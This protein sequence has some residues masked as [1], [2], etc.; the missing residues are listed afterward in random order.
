MVSLRGVVRVSASVPSLS[1]PHP[2]PAEL[3][4][5][6]VRSLSRIPALTPDCSGPGGGPQ[7]LTR[8]PACP[9]PETKPANP[10]TPNPA[11]PRLTQSSAAGQTITVNLALASVRC[12]GPRPQ[13]SAPV[14]AVTLNP[15]PDPSHQP[16]A[17]P[18]LRQIVPGPNTN[19]RLSR[20]WPPVHD[21]NPN[22]RHPRPLPPDTDT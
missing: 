12:T 3:T 2:Q 20:T 1:Q 11:R 4:L 13:P 21:P 17:A 10:Q 14:P 5:N 19:P 8:I 6:P 18:T 9:G 7:P 22:A 16:G 15:A